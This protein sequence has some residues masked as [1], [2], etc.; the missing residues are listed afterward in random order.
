MGGENLMIYFDYKTIQINRKGRKISF[1][2]EKRMRGAI[3][4]IQND[5]RVIENEKRGKVFSQKG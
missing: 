5:F 4:L 2:E 1:D 3:I